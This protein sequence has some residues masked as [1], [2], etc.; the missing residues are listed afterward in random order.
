MLNTALTGISSVPQQLNSP[1][2]PQIESLSIIW[3]WFSASSLFAPWIIL[4]L[5]FMQAAKALNE[6]AS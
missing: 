2:S 5:V 6:F 1:A 4:G 3:N